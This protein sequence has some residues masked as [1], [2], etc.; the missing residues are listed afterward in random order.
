MGMNSEIMGLRPLHAPYPLELNVI[1]SLIAGGFPNP[2]SGDYFHEAV[3]INEILITN[4]TSTYMGYAWSDSMEPLI[5]EGAILLVDKSL[6]IRNGN[7]VAGTYD[8]D[9][10]M[11]RYW[12]EGDS[13]TLHSENP[14]YSPIYI[15]EGIPFRIFGRITRVIQSL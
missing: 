12:K 15:R 6:E 11:K 4:Q 14:K 9:W 5:Y 10:F 2:A 3:N 13:I 7:Y 8:G 1:G